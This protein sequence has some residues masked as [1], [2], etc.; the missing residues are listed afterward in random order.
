MESYVKNIGSKVE[1]IAE[2]QRRWEKDTASYLKYV[3]S[4]STAAVQNV[5]TK[6]LPQGFKFGSKV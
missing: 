6:P 2:T 1:E 3:E 4:Q 5:Q